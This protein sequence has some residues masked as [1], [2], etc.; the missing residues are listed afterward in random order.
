MHPFVFVFE[1]A[2]ILGVILGGNRSGWLTGAA[3][4]GKSWIAV[5]N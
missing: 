2:L 4:S 5:H 1:G 3:T